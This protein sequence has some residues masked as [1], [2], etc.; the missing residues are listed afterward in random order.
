MKR[1]I[2]RASARPCEAEGIPAL[3]ERALM[4]ATLI[5]GL[6][7]GSPQRCS[8]GSRDVLD[9]GCFNRIGGRHSKGDLPDVARVEVS[10]CYA[11]QRVSLVSS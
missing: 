3:V 9:D 7:E 2:R 5:D 11:G 4:N 8:L 10:R 6:P 1:P